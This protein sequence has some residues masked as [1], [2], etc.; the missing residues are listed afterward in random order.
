MIIFVIIGIIIVILRSLHGKVLWKGSDVS[1]Y[2]DV[3][4]YIQSMMDF[5]TDVFFAYT[6][7]LKNQE[8]YFIASLLFTII[9]M[10]CSITF[11]IYWI[12]GW[13]RVTSISVSI[14][15]PQRII[16]YLHDYSMTLILFTILANF[17]SAVQLCQ[18][19]FLLNPMFN[20]SLKKSE[21]DRLRIW[22][23]INNTLLEVKLN[24]PY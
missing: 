10:V 15:I 1:N 3:L 14:A 4:R 13:R 24:Q 19:R 6:M 5:W 16:D 23:F 17:G 22:K 8:K 12:F 7:Y 20:F 18:S 21:N 2:N 9:P 11:V